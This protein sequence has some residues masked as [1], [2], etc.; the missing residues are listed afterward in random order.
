MV[1]GGVIGE[2]V[3]CKSV[4]VG[5]MVCTCVGIESC[6]ERVFEVMRELAVPKEVEEVEWEDDEDVDDEEV[7]EVVE[8][9]S[10]EIGLLRVYQGGGRAQLKTQDW[11]SCILKVCGATTADIR[12]EWAAYGPHGIC[13]CTPMR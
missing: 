2:G 6:S 1:D 3:V 5:S 4:V 7:D 11:S 12:C 9:E 10:R 13:D 8:E